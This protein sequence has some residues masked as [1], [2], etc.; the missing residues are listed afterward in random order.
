MNHR[1]K[2]GA[3]ALVSLA[4]LLTGCS[5]F[6]IGPLGR[7]AMTEEKRDYT[8]ECS[9]PALEKVTDPSQYP[10]FAA[11][12]GRKDD[13]LAAIDGTLDYFAKPSSQRRGMPYLDV[14]HAR[15]QRSLELFRDVVTRAQSASELNAM[16]VD[17]F[18]VYRSKGW[19]GTGDVL[20]TGY[21][22]PIFKAS[23]TE[24]GEFRYPLYQRPK[25]LLA[26]E[27]GTPL[28]WG[29][30]GT[31]SPSRADFDNGALKGRNLELAW[32]RDPLEV[33]IVHVQGSAKLEMQDGRYMLVG[34]AGKTERAYSGLGQNLVEEG[35]IPKDELSLRSV[36]AWM[37]S[38]PSEATGY[39]QRNES[40]VFFH[41]INAGPFGSLNIP[42]TSYRTLATDMTRYPPGGI[43]FVNCEI[44]ASGGGHAQFRQF[45]I[46]Q[47]T[48]GAIRACGR[49]DIYTGIGPEA[50]MI[51]GDTYSVGK[52]WYIYAKPGR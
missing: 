25:E 13:L 16:I 48:G 29:S 42:V 17:A 45:M 36:K 30:P 43:A 20:F 31:P 37:R 40:Y 14:D 10:D 34:Y 9:G 5:L 2:S 22:S 23:K 27:W 50:E 38:H 21:C 15:A 8:D 33:F 19:H 49:A 6:D 26:D 11:G 35:E 51:A 1:I 18:E 32:L 7:T 3:L 44:G 39:M 52:V 46:D 4:P 41:E 12:Y 28:G 47:D 24:T